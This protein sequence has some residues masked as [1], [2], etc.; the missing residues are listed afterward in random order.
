M[1]TEQVAVQFSYYY[2]NIRKA[3]CGRLAWEGEKGVLVVKPVATATTSPSLRVVYD[4]HD[5][6]VDRHKK[7]RLLLKDKHGE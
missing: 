2:R 5:C 7:T 3:C 1:T 4:V 6:F